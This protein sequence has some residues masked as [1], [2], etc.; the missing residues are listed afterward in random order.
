[1]AT[2]REFRTSL[3]P[4][5][6]IDEDSGYWQ[7]TIRVGTEDLPLSVFVDA[8]VNDDMLTRAAALIEDITD[9]RSLGLAA[10]RERE[11]DSIVSDFFEFHQEEL[12]HVAPP[13]SSLKQL[14]AALGL[15]GI[16]VHSNAD[17][18][19]VVLDFSFG[20]QHCDELLAV[21]FSP[22]RVVSAVSHES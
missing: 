7:G 20:R 9:L 6:P 2:A 14:I 5:I 17:S 16:G 13:G 4:P 19:L 12:P 22:D 21:K 8:S 1:M 15:V 3:H 10:I 18:F 11:S